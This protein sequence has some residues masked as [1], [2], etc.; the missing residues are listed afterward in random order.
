MSLSRIIDKGHYIFSKIPLLVYLAIKLRNQCLYLIQHHLSD[1]TDPL[2]NGEKEIAGLIARDALTFIDVGANVGNW[3]SL[4]LDLAP[5][6]NIK[7]LLFEPSDDAFKKLENRFNHNQNIKIIQACVADKKGIMKFYE[8]PE[9]GEGSSLVKS[10]SNLKATEKNIRVTTLDSE[11][12]VLNWDYIDFLKIDAEG[13]DFKVVLGASKLLEDQRIG[14]VQFEYNAPWSAA[15]STLTGAISF[16]NN[17]EYR[18]FLLKNKGLY[19]IQ[20][21]FY[22]EYFGYSNFVAVSPRK[23][24]GLESFIQGSI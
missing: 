11:V 9:A 8:E 19:E 14:V 4:F 10:F 22:G 24:R 20:Y 3:S 5:T 1:G 2:K 12:N 13:Y 7:G 6:K 21:H 23:M 18:V 16:F 15:S 17:L